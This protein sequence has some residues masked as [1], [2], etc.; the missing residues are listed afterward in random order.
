MHRL[1]PRVPP[2]EREAIYALEARECVLVLSRIVDAMRSVFE[3]L[4]LEDVRRAPW[5]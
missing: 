5:I 3:E 4:D 2:V 1:Y